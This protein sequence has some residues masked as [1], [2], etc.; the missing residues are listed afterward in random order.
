MH[1]PIDVTAYKEVVHRI[2]I[3]YYTSDAVTCTIMDKINCMKIQY[4]KNILHFK[5]R[6][7]KYNTFIIH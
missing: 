4:I 3:S 6:M 5:Y 2:C 1:Y 7:S